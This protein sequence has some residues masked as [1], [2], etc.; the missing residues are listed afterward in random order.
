MWGGIPLDG[1][2]YLEQRHQIELKVPYVYY[3]V[4]LCLGYKTKNLMSLSGFLFGVGG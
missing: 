4:W 1:D 2:M 3:A